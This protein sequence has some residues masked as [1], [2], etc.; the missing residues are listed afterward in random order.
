MS[1]TASYLLFSI[2][3]VPTDSFHN[4]HSL[5][6]FAL[7]SLEFS[8]KYAR[9]YVSHRNY[10]KLANDEYNFKSCCPVTSHIED[11][12]SEGIMGGYLW[13]GTIKWLSRHA[14]RVYTL[15]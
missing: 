6:M 10:S 12:E 7:E 15:P 3:I 2:Q 5:T 4:Q 11:Q 1:S 8:D 9:I 13:L 14:E